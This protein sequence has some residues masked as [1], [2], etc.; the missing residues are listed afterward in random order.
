MGFG[1]HVARSTVD[2]EPEGTQRIECSD[3]NLRYACGIVEAGTWGRVPLVQLP[4]TRC[5]F[6]RLPGGNGIHPRGISSRNGSPVFWLMGVPNDRIFCSD[7][8]LRHAPG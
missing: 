7:R 1:V 6:A 2:G 4:G 8:Q 5:L 3:L